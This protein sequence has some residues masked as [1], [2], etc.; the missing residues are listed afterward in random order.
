MADVS[1]PT[2]TFT[3]GNVLDYWLAHAEGL[4]VEPLGVPVERVVVSAPLGHAETLIVR[5]PVTRRRRAIPA[6]SIEAVAP[7]AGHLLL[8]TEPRGT[9]PRIPRPSSTSLTAA[10]ATAA[11]ARSIAVAHAAGAGR[12]TR[13]GLTTGAAWLRPRVALAAAA[14]LRAARRAGDGGRRLAPHLAAGARTT[15]ATGL[16]LLLAAAGAARALGESV[17]AAARQAASAERLR[18]GRRGLDAGD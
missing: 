16:R 11:R 6:A 10:A 17:A 4:T 15:V 1:A 3:R 7:S 2:L 5:S 12:S 9:G 14:G 18:A 8:E 13:A